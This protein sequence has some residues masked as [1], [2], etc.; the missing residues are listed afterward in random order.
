MRSLILLLSVII[1]ATSFAKKEV[2]VGG[3][4]FPP[5]VILKNNVPSGMALDLIAVLNQSQQDYHFKFKL[6][7]AKRRYLDFS[8]KK[9]DLIFFESIIW[10]WQEEPIEPTK[11]I[12]NG[13]EVFIAKA[14]PGRD[15]TF[16]ST[17][18]G[19]TILGIT[20][21]HYQ[22]ANLVTD[23]D[24]LSKYF[25]M[26]LGN[27]HED[28]IKNV[29]SRDKPTIAIVTKSYLNLFLNENPKFRDKLL[30]SDKFDQIYRHT[31]LV[32]KDNHPTVTEMNNL[33]DTLR[34]KGRLDD[35][36]KK[37]GK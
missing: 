11:V 19:K 5:F 8:K 13:G 22:F 6:T 4:E 16:F 36:W 27:N 7:S 25:N 24:Y 10:G 37:Y 23:K 21:Y 9:Y 14:V 17:F 30:V 35:V 20:G 2:I 3:Y 31:I 26:R 29:V 18:K 15:K 33:I 28:N 1:T 12:L 32:R 34:K